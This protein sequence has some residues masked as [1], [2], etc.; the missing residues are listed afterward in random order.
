[1]QAGFLTLIYVSCKLIVKKKDFGA[2][3]TRHY[4][5]SLPIKLSSV[6]SF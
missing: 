6:A 2:D 5:V 1:M 4:A 3:G